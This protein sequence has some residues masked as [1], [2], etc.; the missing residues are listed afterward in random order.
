MKIFG[1][2]IKIYLA[3]CSECGRENVVI[4]IHTK[5]WFKDRTIG[6]L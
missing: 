3:K 6:P 2:E 1:R 4:E 5:K